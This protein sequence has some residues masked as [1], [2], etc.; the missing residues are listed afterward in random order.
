MRKI[1]LLVVAV[2][3][4]ALAGTN[5][6]HAAGGYGAAGCGLGAILFGD[7]PGF[8]Q[9][10]AATFNGS[11]GSQ[12]F[13]ITFGTSNCKSTD[14]GA[15]SA[16]AYVEA[17]RQQLAKE[18]S[19]GSGE[20]LAGLASVAGCSD[21]RAVGGRLQVGYKQIFT[22][23]DVSDQQVGQNVVTLLKSDASLSCT[24]I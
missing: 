13:G 9:V 24:K 19:R 1:A 17:N 16:V 8:M 6:A 20:T 18:I 2:C 14:G 21:A 10:I 3:G 7:K 4:F 22:S 15:P 11:F 23:A 5:V 12:T